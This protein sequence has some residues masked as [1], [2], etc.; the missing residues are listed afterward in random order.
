MVLA[1]VAV[2]H[3]SPTAHR[4]EIVTHHGGIANEAVEIVVELVVV[5]LAA[6]A[7][8]AVAVVAVAVV[9]VALDSVAAIVVVVLAVPLGFEH[10]LF[11]VEEG[12]IAV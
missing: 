9:V 8:A 4:L 3:Q 10:R 1:A 11:V 7:A 6:V 2:A 5:E 12:D